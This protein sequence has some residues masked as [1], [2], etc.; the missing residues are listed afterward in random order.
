MKKSCIFTNVKLVLPEKI[1]PGCV[2]VENG[3]IA[4]VEESG[5][6]SS[7]FPQSWSGKNNPEEKPEVIDGGGNYLSP[8]FIDIHNHGR[9]GCDTMDRKAS[10][11]ETIARNQAEHGVTGFLAGTSSIPWDNYLDVLGFLAEYYKA[12]TERFGRDISGGAVI[13]GAQYL[14]I[15]SE[16]VFFSKEKRGAHNPKFLRTA[17]TID[18]LHTLFDKAGLAL[19]VIALSPELR[20]ADEWIRF[21]TGKGIVAAAAHSNADYGQ[22]LAGINLG[23]TLATHTFNGMRSLSHQDPGILGAVLDDSRVYCELIADGIHLSPIILSIVYKV[24]GPEKIILVSDSVA[25]GGIPD[26]RYEHEGLIVVVKEGIIRLEDGRLA[27]SSLSLDNAVKNTVKLGKVP[28]CHAVL[29]ASLNPAKILGLDGQKGSIAPGKDA[30]LIIFNEN[31]DILRV[32]I[33]GHHF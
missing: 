5:S 10:S 1:V 31:I 8:G 20:G 19:R 7:A 9:L 14:G 17:L 28:L 15:Y 4:A 22:A 32:F 30:D 21:I 3:I 33:R 23:I 27:G 12:E 16:G 25:A 13:K 11:M 2:L 26:G 18:D 29:A 24:K 6:L